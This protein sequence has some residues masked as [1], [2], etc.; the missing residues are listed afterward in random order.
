MVESAPLFI[1]SCAEGYMNV[2]A[3]KQCA[4]LLAPSVVCLLALSFCLGC[5]FYKRFISD[6]ELD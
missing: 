2:A 4:I 3:L 1:E 6:I 5:F